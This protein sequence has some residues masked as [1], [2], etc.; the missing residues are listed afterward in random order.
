MC[1]VLSPIMEGE[2]SDRFVH[3]LLQPTEETLHS[4]LNK[5][6]SKDGQWLEDFLH[7]RGLEVSKLNDKLG[8]RRQVTSNAS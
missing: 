5:L 3:L 6:S 1:L 8:G 4:L 7:A 2:H